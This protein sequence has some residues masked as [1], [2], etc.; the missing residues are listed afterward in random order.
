MS[1]ELF[2][3]STPIGNL[4]DISNRVKDALS[5]S[6]LVLA[7]DTRVSGKLLHHLRIRTPMMSCHDFN[8][9]KR[10]SILE[11]AAAQNGTISLVSDAGT[12]LVSDPG[13]QLV[14]KAIELGLKV[15]PIPGPSALLAALVGSG[16]PCERFIF[17]AFLPEKVS[18]RKRRLESLRHESRTVVFYIAP[19][20]LLSILKEVQEICGDRMAC[21]AR[22]LTKL[23]EEFLRMNLSQLRSYVEKHELRGEFVLVL[24]GAPEG[25]EKRSSP[26]DVERRLR[27][28][29]ASGGRLKE[30]A[31]VLAPEV[32][33]SS[34]ELYKLGLAIK[35][36]QDK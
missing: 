8:E 24:A 4:G 15:T 19:S 20:N 1:G 13:Y 5:R 30:I 18:E 10:F 27:D 22:E 25:Q 35:E 29:L 21:L 34:S 3:V 23:H 11:D 7:E 32:G 16:L 6:S 17:E 12:P 28:L 26:E 14:R 36:A 33:W 31:G 2:I 9:G